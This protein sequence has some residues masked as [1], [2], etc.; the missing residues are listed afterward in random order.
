[1]SDI[2]RR[3]LART[4]KLVGLPLGHAG[5][6]AVGLGR[7]VGGAPAEAIAAELQARTAEQ[8]FAVLGELKG[9]AMKFGQ[10]LSVMEAAMPEELAGPYRATLT[11]L[12]EAAPPMPVARVHAILAQQLGPRWRSSKFQSFEDHPVA[13]ASIGQVHRAVWRDGRT[14]AVK[15]QY[16][17]AGEAL[18]SDIAQLSRV[19]R[20]AGAWIPGIAMGPILDEV[21]ARMSEELDYDLEATNQKVFARAFRGDAEV[22]V[23]DVL[24]HSDQVIV[25]EWVDGR[26]LAQVISD[27]T[28]A[29][30]DQAAG[31]YLEFL[32][33]GPNRARLLHADPHPGN[34]RITPDGRLGVLDFGAVNRLPAGMPSAMGEI[35]THTL[36]Q[37]E[38]ALGAVLRRAG[39]IRPGVE[40][41]DAA[42]V[43]YLSSFVEPLRH[44]TFTFSRSWLRSV[45]ATIQDPRREEFLVGLRF[46]LPP[47]YMLIHRVWL[48]SIGVLCQV[49]GTVPMRDLIF[50]HVPGIDESVIPPAT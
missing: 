35:I 9:G 4:A 23:P 50:A 38:A 25:S 15:V 11:K 28:P 36:A 39:F 17:G 8:L 48:G 47:D 20:L 2:P 44:E 43:R 6:A 42:L 46:N 40:V 12:Q 10:A 13:A 34:F 32:L 29:E 18:L 30:R 5:R 49:G 21:K 24:A 27:G 3:S 31:L 45:S 14:V 37:N 1:M 22:L 41:S 7:R 19:A 26:P 16:P 33:R